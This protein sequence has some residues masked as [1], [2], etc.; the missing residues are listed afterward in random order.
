DGIRAFHVTGVQT[1]AL[2]ICV[3]RWWRVLA[4]QFRS[5]LVYVL[6]AAA[7]LSLAVGLLPGRSPQYTEAILILA[8]VLANAAFGFFQD[9]RAELG[10]ASRS[11]RGS[12]TAVPCL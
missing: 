11:E 8:L 5:V 2:P 6:V 10:R 9:F 3:L 12:S 7:A 1:C 4:A